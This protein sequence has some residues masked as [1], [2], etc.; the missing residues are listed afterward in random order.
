MKRAKLVVMATPPTD[1]LPTYTVDEYNALEAFSNIKHDYVDGVIRA[2]CA[3]TIEQYVA[4]EEFSNVKHEFLDG[5][6]LAM[7]G[8]TYEHS[9]LAVGLILQLGVQLKG[10]GCYVFTSDARVHATEAEFIA[11]P[12]VT[13]CCGKPRDGGAD[14]L[15]MLNPTVIIEILSHSTEKYDRR[16]KFERYKLIESFEEYVLVSQGTPQIE[17]RRR[18]DGWAEVGVFRAGD[19]VKLTSINCQISVD[20]LY[21]D[22]LTV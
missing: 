9:R 18:T 19:L 21:E 14:P 4:M 2:R 5:Q 10:R 16:T 20:E 13:V 8:G 11:Y 22:A 7:G 17:V 1:D 6:A 3:D 15:A 12:D